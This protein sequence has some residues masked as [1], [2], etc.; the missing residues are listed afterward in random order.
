MDSGLYVA[1]AD[2]IARGAPEALGPA[3]HGYPALIALA[4]LVFPGVEWPGRVIALLAGLALIPLVYAL[5]RRT[6][7]P[8]AASLAAW[9]V[10][11]HPL[12]AMYS[13]AIMTE[14]SFLA[15]AYLGLWAVE[16]G[17]LIGGGA[18][19]GVSYWIRPEALVIAPA[20]AAL[21]RGSWARRA[22][23]LAAFALALVPFLVYLRVERGTWSLTPKEVLVAPPLEG[24]YE[25]EPGVPVDAPATSLAR[26]FATAI[27]AALPRY[28]P[29]LGGHLV[30]LWHAWPLPLLALSAVGLARR[31]G[32]LAAPLAQL[33]V[34][35]LLAVVANGRFPMLLIPALAVY[36]AEGARWSLEAIERRLAGR[37]PAAPRIA[38]AGVALAG[39]AIA[40]LGPPGRHVLHFDEQ[41]MAVMRDAGLWLRD[42]GQPRA[43][44]MDRK[45]YIPLFARMRHVQ[46]PDEGYERIVEYA[47]RTGVEYLALEEYI[48]LTLRPQLLPLVTD[49]AFISRERRLKLIYLRRDRPLEGVAIFEVVRDSQSSR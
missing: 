44:V 19:L 2:A 22:G 16:R 21:A 15:L 31:R 41:P 5:A 37:S 6:L 47:Q 40:W 38:L 48:L 18:L 11:L 1:M 24:G 32:A 49:S 33:A 30:Q 25:V 39:L 3:H 10:A 43:R 12:L 4:S 20:A 23:L 46:L 14:T 29:N 13:V 17:R 27:P 28:L 42:Q 45:A 26:R 7:P 36:A 34:L 35:P 8:L 9:L